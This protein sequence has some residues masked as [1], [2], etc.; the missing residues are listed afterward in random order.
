MEQRQ[1][2]VKEYTIKRIVWGKDYA[3][4]DLIDI[5]LEPMT[6]QEASTMRQKQMNPL[7]WFICKIDN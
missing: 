5:G 4:K 2:K 7:N 6:L 1:H 3:I